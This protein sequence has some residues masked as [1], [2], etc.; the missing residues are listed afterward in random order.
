M[1]TQDGVQPTHTSR[2]SL[3]IS[4]TYLCLPNGAPLHSSSKVAQRVR[5]TVAKLED[6]SL[7]SG[8]HIM[9]GE[10]EREG[11]RERERYHSP[12]LPLTFMFMS[13]N[14][15]VCVHIHKQNIPM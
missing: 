6:P 2:S 7:V 3:L 4:K 12:S 11:K 15:C 14:V 13:R 10:G 5:A 1:K 8:T 9:E